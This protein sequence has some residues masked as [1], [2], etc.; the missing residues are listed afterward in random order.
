MK[1]RVDEIEEFSQEALE[2]ILIRRAAIVAKPLLEEDHGQRIELAIVRIG[3]DLFGLDVHSIRDIHPC[4]SI[5]RLPRV[6][7]WIVGVTNIG[8]HILAVLDLQS[9]F[10]LAVKEMPAKI[11]SNCY[12]IRLITGETE[13]ALLVDEVL[14]IESLAKSKIQEATDATRGLPTEY[15]RGVYD[16]IAGCSSLVLV[17][18]LS[19]LLADPRLIIQEEIL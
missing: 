5:T 10:D 13:L 12:L 19:N 6:P 2:Q 1:D 8:G 14:S 15:V 3:K 4:T 9:L 16:Q 17:L 7:R 11:P 18:D